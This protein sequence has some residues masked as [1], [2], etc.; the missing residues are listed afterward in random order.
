MDA[1]VASILAATVTEQSR[2]GLGGE[3]PMLIKMTGRPVMAISGIG[4][5]P[6]KATVEY[7]PEPPARNRGKTA[8]HLAPIPMQGI[9][10]AIT[11]G[12]FAGLILALQQFGTKSFAEV[13]EPAI[14]YAGQG[15]VM[16]DE[17]GKMLQRLPA[18]SSPCGPI[19]RSSSIPTGWSQ[20]AASSSANRA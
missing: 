6:A 18:T 11:P 5:A 12:L 3:V 9:R 1:G 15:F 10:S 7:Y 4:I 16:P 20:S 14:E 13:A 2:F 19:R 17:F 8:D